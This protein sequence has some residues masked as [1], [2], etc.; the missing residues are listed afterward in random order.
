MALVT[1]SGQLAA[2]ADG[3]AG[4]E[5]YCSEG[6]LLGA[7]ARAAVRGRSPSGLPLL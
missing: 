7:T 2:S 5:S 1:S 3:K 4:G 6:F